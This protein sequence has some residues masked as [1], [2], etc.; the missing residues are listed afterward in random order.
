MFPEQRDIEQRFRFPPNLHAYACPDELRQPAGPRAISY[1][2]GS[3]YL[4]FARVLLSV[5]A[6]KNADDRYRAYDIIMSIASRTCGLIFGSGAVE[7]IAK[8]SR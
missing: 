6:G 8:T 5:S 1:L 7:I 2:M 4:I 3:Q